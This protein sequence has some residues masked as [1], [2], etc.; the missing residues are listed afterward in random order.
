[1]MQKVVID[2]NVIISAALSP[3][4]LPAKIISLIVKNE[5]IQF[6]YSAAILDEYREI[7]S[8]KK[9][10]ILPEVQVSIIKAVKENGILIKPTLSEIQFSDESDRTFYDT[11]KAS[12]AILITGNI[13]HFPT[14]PFIMTPADFLSVFTKE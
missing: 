3:S 14:E 4:G 2:T 6:Y 13:K 12:G 5:E 10:N 1:M 8:R 7:L 11:A 9:L